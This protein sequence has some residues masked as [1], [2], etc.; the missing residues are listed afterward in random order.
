MMDLEATVNKIFVG[1][2]HFFVMML[3]TSTLNKNILSLDSV[4]EDT[5]SENKI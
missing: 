2:Q 3:T 5:F 1:I 4:S